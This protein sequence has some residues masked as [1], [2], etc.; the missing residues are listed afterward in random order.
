MVVQ[1]V[2]HLRTKGVFLISLAVQSVFVLGCLGWDKI[3]LEISTMYMQEG[4]NLRLLEKKYV[5]WYI[6]KIKSVKL[7]LISVSMVTISRK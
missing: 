5:F 6:C 1:N 3:I 2:F 4:A 7:D